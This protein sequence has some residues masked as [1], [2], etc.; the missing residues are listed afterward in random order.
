ME[1]DRETEAGYD[2]LGGGGGG[3]GGR[4]RQD[5]CRESTRS[6]SSKDKY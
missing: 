3:V 2:G 1:R 4:G 5:K 6:Y